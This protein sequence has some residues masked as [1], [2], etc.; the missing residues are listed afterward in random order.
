[1][2][3][4][5][6]SARAGIKASPRVFAL[7]GG[8]IAGSPFARAV[9]ALCYR[10]L[11]SEWTK[12]LSTSPIRG[13]PAGPLETLDRLISALP[14]GD[15]LRRELL[16]LRMSVAENEDMVAEARQAIEKLEQIVKKVT[17]PANRIGTFLSSPS[18]ARPRRSSSAVPI[19]IAISIPRIDVRSL[20]RGTRVLVNEAYV[21]VGDLGYDKTGPVTKVTEVL[22]H[23]RLRVGQEHGIAIARPAAQRPADEGEAQ[24]GR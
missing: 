24:G 16:S 21:I 20:R 12:N 15:L 9:S 13:P 17:S 10:R 7:V 3:R 19:T 4:G 22:G 8:E 11:Y 5:R 6:C 2:R 1:M 23:D 14:P 18:A